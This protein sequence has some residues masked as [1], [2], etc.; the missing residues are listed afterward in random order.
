MFAWLANSLSRRGI[1]LPAGSVI[2]TG[3]LTEP[4]PIAPGSSAV[5]RF[6]GG[7]EVR[8]SIAAGRSAA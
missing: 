8:M 7:T 6:D 2:L 3:S 5:A 1:G 4:H